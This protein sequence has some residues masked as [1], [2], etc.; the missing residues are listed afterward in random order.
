MSTR[1]ILAFGLSLVATAT[2]MP[3]TAGEHAVSLLTFSSATGF[4]PGAGIITDRHGNLFGTTIIGGTGPCSGGAGCGTVYELSPPSSKGG[5]WIFSKLH[6]FQGPGDGESPFAPLT[7]DRA[8]ALYGYA[9][10]SPGT[11]FQV[12]PPKHSGGTWT[13]SVIYAFTGGADGDLLNVSAPLV[14][15]HGALYGVASGGEKACGQAGCGSVFRLKSAGDV[16]REET[17]YAFT[18]GADGGEPNWITGPDSSGG[19]YV[20]TSMGNGAVVRV[21]P[22]R[23]KTWGASVITEFKTGGR[24]LQPTNVILAPDGTIYGIASDNHG[25][26]AFQLTPPEGPGALS[27]AKRL[28]LTRSG[29]SCAVTSMSWTL[30]ATVPTGDCQISKSLS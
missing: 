5:S 2:V 7:K 16:W 19:F 28:A 3:A 11:I 9:Y 25:G 30:A 26:I 17:L 18:G 1:T 21:A 10:G 14:A 27:T 24:I 12:A 15:V 13:Y 4:G 20:S 29:T 6:D 22:H 8:G 23:G